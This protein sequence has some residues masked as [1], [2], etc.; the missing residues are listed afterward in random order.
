MEALPAQIAMEMAMVQRNAMMG[1]IKQTAQVQQQIADML[2]V[3]V[4][5]R[6]GS[7]DLFA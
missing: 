4:S 7:V 6:G 3:T 1:M 5:S 2:A